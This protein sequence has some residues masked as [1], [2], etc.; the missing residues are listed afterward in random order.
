MVSEILESRASIV[1]TCYCLGGQP[2][3][4]PGARR[5]RPRVSGDRARRDWAVSWQATHQDRS[6]GDSLVSEHREYLLKGTPNLLLHAVGHR[7]GKD[8]SLDELDAAQLHWG[9]RGVPYPENP[10]LDSR[11]SFPA[12]LVVRVV[13]TATFTRLAPQRL[14]RSAQDR[15]WSDSA[16][17]AGWGPPE[18]GGGDWNHR[19]IARQRR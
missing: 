17:G 16:V 6:S 4:C 12:F 1:R 14:G 10:S 19:D 13:N 2:A 15:I 7:L 5:L 8:D 11:H 9:G 3:F 18:L